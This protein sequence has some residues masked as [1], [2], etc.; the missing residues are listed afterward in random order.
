MPQ[1]SCLGP[2]LFLVY[3]N[4]LPR[5]VNN[6]TTSM[7]ADDMSLCLQSK[8]LS[9][10][11][12]ALNEDLSHLDTWFTSNKLSLNVAKTQSMLVS[13]KAKRNALN[14]SNQNLPMK[15][16]G[17]ELEVVNKI[18]CLGVQVDNSLDWKSQVQAVY[19]KVP[20]SLDS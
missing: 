14:M 17:T 9:Q 13:T 7:Y 8:D 4:D 2:L 15:I 5:G 16:H 3:I 6:S 20:E 10:L 19:L 11:N 12:E 18:K 1:G